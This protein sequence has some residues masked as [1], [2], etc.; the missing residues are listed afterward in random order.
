[1]PI[2]SIVSKITIPEFIVNYEMVT[3]D[4]IVPS[5]AKKFSTIHTTEYDHENYQNNVYR[6]CSR[7]FTDV[8]SNLRANRYCDFPDTAW[9]VSK[10]RRTGTAAGPA[11]QNS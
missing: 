6:R 7:S 2:S 1:M 3:I 8:S 10:N 9:R 5:T 4:I 11:V